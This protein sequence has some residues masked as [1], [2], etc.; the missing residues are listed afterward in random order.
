MSR[1]LRG[2]AASPGV[3][4]GR[5]FLY[6]S[7]PTAAV[8]EFRDAPVVERA[9]LAAAIV[10][11]ENELTALEMRTRVQIGDSAADIIDFQRELLQDPELRSRI[12]G[13]MDSM[14]AEAAVVAAFDHYAALLQALPEASLRSRADDLRDL[15]QRLLHALAGDVANSARPAA[16]VVLVARMLP[17]SDLLSFERTDLCA[18]C[19][20]ENVPT[21]HV[22]ILARSLGLPVVLGA[23]EVLAAAA[24]SAMLLVDGGTGCIVID[25]TETEIGAVSARAYVP[26][27]VIHAN[28]E[29]LVRVSA[30]IG[31]LAEAMVAHV[32]GADGI[33]LLRT[34][35]LLGDAT[36]SAPPG[37]DEQYAAY[38]AVAEHVGDAPLVVR[39]FDLGGDKPAS[40][41]PRRVEA[42]PALGVRGMRLLLQQQSLLRAQIR[43]LVRL[44]QDFDVRVL[45]PLVTD[46]SEFVQLRAAFDE[47]CVELDVRRRPL[48]GVMIEVPAAALL[49]DAFAPHADFFS[50]GA[51]D[52]AQYVLATDRDTAQFGRYGDALHPA[53]LRL[54]EMT[55]RAAHA[56]KKTVTLCGEIAG[57]VEAVPLLIG[58]DV[59]ELS[60][61][62]ALISAV[63]EAAACDQQAARA[64]AQRCLGANDIAA[65]RELLS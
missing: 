49:A 15:K 39:L 22:V 46:L 56:H 2:I 45:A 20:I 63:R 52:L 50:I 21:S 11:A 33:G 3:A 26:A 14:D 41:L 19:L 30:S 57:R 35:F 38:R 29:P 24:A 10:R 7:A 51:N 62:P 8:R 27:R 23:D 53:V 34:E 17:P 37:E 5:A 13:V 18:L 40:F 31:G 54:I 43:G 65:L 44:A 61:A 32:Q 25:P 28:A 48:L 4:V 9:R 6:A 42:N 1:V 12:D 16:P 59:D 36:R 64:L 47:V 55:V 60:V 58:L